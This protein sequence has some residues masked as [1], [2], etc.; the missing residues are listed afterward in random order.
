VIEVLVVALAVGAV[1][2]AAVS[3]LGLLRLPDVYARV[4]AGGKA[5]TLGAGLAV[6]AAAIAVGL[7]LATVKLLFLLGF[8]YLTAPAAAHAIARAARDQDIEPWT[9]DDE[10]GSP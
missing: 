4:H 3:V 9:R 1:A 8:L 5:D 10:E 6:A 2:F 7:D